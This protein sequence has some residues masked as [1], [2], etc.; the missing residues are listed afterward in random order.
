MGPNTAI[1]RTSCNRHLRKLN[2]NLEVCLE[3]NKHRKMHKE[4]HHDASD[5]IALPPGSEADSM[6]FEVLAE[7]GLE[8]KEKSPFA[9]TFAIGPANGGC[10]FLTV[11]RARCCGTRRDLGGSAG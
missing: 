3:N 5:E 7:I 6:P 1:C 10:H 2:S 8:I 4:R 11:P 9:R